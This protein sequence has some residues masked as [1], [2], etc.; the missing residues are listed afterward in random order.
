M[1]RERNIFRAPAS[2][3]AALAAFPALL[4]FQETVMTIRASAQTMRAQSGDPIVVP[5]V[6]IAILTDWHIGIGERPNAHRGEL[7]YQTIRS[8][9]FSRRQPRYR[10][11]AA[12]AT[13]PSTH[14]MMSKP[15]PQIARVPLTA[16]RPEACPYCGSH[17]QPEGHPQKKL[18]I[19]QFW[20]CSACKRTSR[21]DRQPSAT[22]PIR[23][24]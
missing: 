1:V 24:A 6:M 16:K 20:R 12:R 11:A 21:P 3:V 13:M 15:T 14:H 2:R 23:C 5:P 22:R 7:L 8:L 17:S 19:V 9:P 18:E 10:N 4:A